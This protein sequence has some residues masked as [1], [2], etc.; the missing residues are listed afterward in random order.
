MI[1]VEHPEALT[2]P[3]TDGW[4]RECWQALADLLAIGA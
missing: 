4:P 3:T 1:V 2:Q